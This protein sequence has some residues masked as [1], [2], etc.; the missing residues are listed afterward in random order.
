[1]VR[2]SVWRGGAAAEKSCRDRVDVLFVRVK[3]GSAVGIRKCENDRLHASI[4][5]LL[6][7]PFSILSEAYEISY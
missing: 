5:L 3:T 2:T 1:M 4:S 7:H 6:H